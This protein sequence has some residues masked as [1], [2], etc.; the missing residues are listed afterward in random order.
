M[1]RDTNSLHGQGSFEYLHHTRLTMESASMPQFD[2][3]LKLLFQ[4]SAS[5][6][7]REIAGVSVARWLN[8]ELPRV[9]NP[10][11]DLLGETTDGQLVHI[12]FQTENDRTMEYRMAEYYLAIYRLL[13]RHPTQIVIYV[14]RQ[15]IGMKERLETPAMSHRYQLV[16][17]RTV[18]SG[19]LLDSP[20]VQDNML[21]ILADLQDPEG[22]A[23]KILATIKQCEPAERATLLAQFLVIAGLRQLERTVLEEANKMA[24]ST[25]TLI[26]ENTVLGPAFAK[27]EQEA[28][29]EGRQ[30]GELSLLCRQLEKRF[31]PIPGWAEERLSK[32]S[33]AELEE[34]GLRLLDAPSLDEL[35]G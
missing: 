22:A 1:L 2:T 20:Q 35:L 9:Q 34:L 26:R 16:D 19:A 33:A 14:G 6:L 32:S 4:R 10:R 8:V 3:T 11:V 23:R 30:E 17:I 7:L 28:R 5:T 24:I 18:S 15:P 31:G 25:E 21:A 27:A 13:G 12:E 29:Q